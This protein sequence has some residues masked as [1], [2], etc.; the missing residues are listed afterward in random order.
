M[1]QLTSNEMDLMGAGGGFLLRARGLFYGFD[2]GDEAAIWRTVVF[3]RGLAS[4]GEY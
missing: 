1:S 4:S 3:P 2:F